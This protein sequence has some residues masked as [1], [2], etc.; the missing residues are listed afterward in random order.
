MSSDIQKDTTPLPA[1]ENFY[2]LYP[3]KALGTAGWI[4]QFP[5]NADILSCI[6]LKYRLDNIMLLM[7]TPGGGCLITAHDFYTHPPLTYQNRYSYQ[8]SYSKF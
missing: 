2:H 4:T 6:H 8:N 7:T 3:S 1:S 5:L